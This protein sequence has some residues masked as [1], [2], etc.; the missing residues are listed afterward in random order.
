MLLWLYCVTTNHIHGE[1]SGRMMR[2]GVLFNNPWRYWFLLLG[3]LVGPTVLSTRELQKH[4]APAGPAGARGAPR[5]TDKN[6]SDPRPRA[7]YGQ[8]VTGAG[9]SRTT[10]PA[11]AVQV[12]VKG[13][14]ILNFWQRNLESWWTFSAALRAEFFLCYSSHVSWECEKQRPNFIVYDMIHD[15]H[16]HSL[17]HIH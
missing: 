6:F 8:V 5:V 7:G 17:T 1:A 14:G 4:R 16:P 13:A 12:R 10:D 2:L 11:R 3:R 9:G 15:H